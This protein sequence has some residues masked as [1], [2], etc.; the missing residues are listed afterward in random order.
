MLSHSHRWTMF[1]KLTREV[2]VENK[3]IGLVFISNLLVSTKNISYFKT[4]IRIIIQ[5]NIIMNHSSKSFV[6][7]FSLLQYK[8]DLVG[9]TISMTVLNVMEDQQLME[10]AQ[11]L[12]TLL[13]N[14]FRQLQK[15]HSVIG[16]LYQC[17]ISKLTLILTTR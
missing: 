9:A 5:C 15:S 3:L 11:N 7:T 4:H 12:G 2:V 17:S 13:A 16:N 8:C 6:W 10:N 14:G 1:M